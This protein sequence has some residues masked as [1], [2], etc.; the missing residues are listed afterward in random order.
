MYI[1]HNLTSCGCEFMKIFILKIIRFYQKFI[2]FYFGRSCR[3]YP[4]CSE[5]TYW[6]IKKHGIIKGLWKG[7]KR[8]LR[9]NPFNKGG[10]DM[11]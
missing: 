1:S 4:T 8:V 9:C 3:F 7:T 5:Y 11:P 10:V 2:S 6:S